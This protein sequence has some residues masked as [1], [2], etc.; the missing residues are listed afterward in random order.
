MLVHR[1]LRE[2]LGSLAE[3]G[4]NA[5]W[6]NLS[7]SNIGACHKRERI[8]IIAYPASKRLQTI[9]VQKRDIAKSSYKKPEQ[10]EQFLL[11]N[12]GNC[13]LENWEKFEGE[14]C[15]DYDGLS[16]KMDRFKGLGNAIVPQIAEILFRQIKDLV[17]DES[18]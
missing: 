12:S 2:V 6:T 7:A 13:Y 4:Y 8:W 10:W 9:K 18:R 11:I 5:E 17:S 16:E 1:G 3:I 14:F 15:G